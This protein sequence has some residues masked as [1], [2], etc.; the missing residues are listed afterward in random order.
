MDRLIEM[1][2]QF[3]DDAGSF[4][5]RAIEADIAFSEAILDR[6]Q[7]VYSAIAKRLYRP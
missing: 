5:N 1:W 4:F 7:I 3:L 6:V 2:E